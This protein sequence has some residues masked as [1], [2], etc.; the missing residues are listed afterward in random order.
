MARA[1]AG[2]SAAEQAFRSLLRRGVAIAL[3]WALWTHRHSAAAAALAGLARLC[4]FTT[5]Q[6]VWYSSAKP[7]GVKLHIQ[8]CKA[9]G[10]LGLFYT[11]LCSEA[12]TAAAP[13]FPA[14]V[15]ERPCCSE[16]AQ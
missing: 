11:E 8:T 12:F 13:F 6:L 2:R 14:L 7:A 16:P 10:T 9:L 3:G 15:G 5:Q 1:T 4:S